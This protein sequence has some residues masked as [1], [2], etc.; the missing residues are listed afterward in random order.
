M[1][2]G[3]DDRIV[4]AVVADMKKH[5][6]A[7]EMWARSWEATAIEV[8][9]STNAATMIRRWIAMLEGRQPPPSS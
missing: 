8:A 6:E 5:A 1:G 3:F 4:A 2:Q 7:H 9:A